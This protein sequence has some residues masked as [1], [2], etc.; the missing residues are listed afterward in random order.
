MAYQHRPTP[1]PEDT[2]AQHPPQEP[3]E[4]A[5]AA[6]R[7]QAWLADR[8]KNGFIAR[9]HLRSSG[10]S[11]DAFDGRPVVGIAN[12]WSDLN[13][14]NGH[15]RQLADSVRR[16]VLDAGGLPME[17]PTMSLG[18]P[19]MRPTSMLYRNLMSIDVEETLRANPVDAV[20]LLGGCDKTTPAQLMGAASVDLPT[21]VVTGGPMVSGSFRGCPIGSGTRSE[22]RRV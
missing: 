10:L 1:S 16:G 4:E 13:P 17:F 19:L 8:G 5:P 15:L 3:D 2:A 11:D 14:C 9:S 7:S 12:S 22:E 21:A 18:E 6:L 20:V